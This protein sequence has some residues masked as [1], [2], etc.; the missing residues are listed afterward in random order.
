MQVNEG[1]REKNPE[2]SR[3]EA[4]DAMLVET[5]TSISRARRHTISSRE[6]AATLPELD[7]LREYERCQK[8][9]VPVPFV[10]K[11]SVSRKS[12]FLLCVRYM[13][14]RMRAKSA[15]RKML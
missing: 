9:N 8:E 11:C 1:E 13:F 2:V 5:Y 3:I 6:Y 15:K 14:M 12:S 7:P 4:F 10:P